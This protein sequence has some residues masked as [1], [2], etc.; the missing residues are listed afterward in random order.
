MGV[1]KKIKFPSP[2]NGLDDT[3]DFLNRIQEFDET[4][5][6]KIL[7]YFLRSMD[8]QNRTIKGLITTCK[9]G[10]QAKLLEKH[11]HWCVQSRELTSNAL[12]QLNNRHDD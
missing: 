7:E 9:N 10:N 6:T 12:K 5:Q 4:K 1:S 11:S 3:K 8:N 2:E